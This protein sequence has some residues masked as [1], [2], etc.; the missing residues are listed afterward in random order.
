MQKVQIIASRA[1]LR[2]LKVR[3]IF[4][5]LDVVPTLLKAFRQLPLGVD[6]FVRV[7]RW[8]FGQEKVP[9]FPVRKTGY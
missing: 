2:I 1:I 5:M 3:F 6:P 8:N 7:R 4:N 9:P